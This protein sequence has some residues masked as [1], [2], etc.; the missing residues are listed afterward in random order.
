MCLETMFTKIHGKFMC[1]TSDSD[2][3]HDQAHY[4][5]KGHFQHPHTGRIY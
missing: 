4:R 2:S 3:F 1:N 5:I